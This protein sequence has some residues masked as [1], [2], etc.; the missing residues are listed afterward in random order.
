MA[1][2]LLLR[3]L[4]RNLQTYTNSNLVILRVALCIAVPGSKKMKLRWSV[5][6]DLKNEA[7]KK[8]ITF[9]HIPLVGTW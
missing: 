8:N 7:R 6:A 1:A 2:S 3:L 5:H 9:T 4:F